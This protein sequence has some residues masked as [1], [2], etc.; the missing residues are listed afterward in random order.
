MKWKEREELAHEARCARCEA[1]QNQ[2]ALLN[3]KFQCSGACKELKQLREF[4]PV[5]V[6]LFVSR[7]KWASTE[8]F[9]DIRCQSCQYPECTQCHKEGVDKRSKDEQMF[10]PTA[11]HYH[12]GKFY[13]R[14]HRFPP[15]T[16][17]G[18]ERPKRRTGEYHSEYNC[19]Q[20]PDWTCTECRARRTAFPECTQCQ[21]EGV[22]KRSQ[23]EIHLTK[24]HKPNQTKNIFLISEI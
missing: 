14:A 8:K 24:T 5:I 20:K 15:C 12:K 4:A 2:D 1:K 11:A 18:A 16:G 10:P 23:D 17:C 19:F 7:L 6:K 3:K 13:C 9:Q 21:E 22:D